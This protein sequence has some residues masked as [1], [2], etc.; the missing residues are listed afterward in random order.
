MVGR[1]NRK[2][3]LGAAIGL[4]FTVGPEARKGGQNYVAAGEP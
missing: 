2:T 3:S 4:L 1:G